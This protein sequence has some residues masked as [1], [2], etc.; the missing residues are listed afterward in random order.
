MRD[1]VC[2]AAGY[3]RGR[4]RTRPSPAS[5]EL[6]GSRLHHPPGSWYRSPVVLSVARSRGG[7][8]CEAPLVAMS[9][10]SV[11]PGCLPQLFHVSCAS[12]V[13]HRPPIVQYLPR[14]QHLCTPGASR[15]FLPSRP[16]NLFRRHVVRYRFV[17]PRSFSTV[18]ERRPSPL[19][20]F[21]RPSRTTRRAHGRGSTS[22]QRATST[23]VV[24]WCLCVYTTGVSTWCDPDGPGC[25][26]VDGST[27]SDRPAG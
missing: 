21:H 17:V 19:A 6:D 22:I 3:G 11:E 1:G 26:E 2:C 4:L 27:R 18:R 8:V 10:R 14:I 24:R 16:H 13:S 25:T 15:R 12:P 9:D 7:S 23:F 5:P 20:T